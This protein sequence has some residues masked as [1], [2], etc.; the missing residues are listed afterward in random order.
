VILSSVGEIRYYDYEFGG[1]QCS[2]FCVGRSVV[3]L[4]GDKIYHSDGELI[5]VG[6]HYIFSGNSGGYLVNLCHDIKM[7]CT[8]F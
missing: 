4:N 8:N 1:E 3:N 5:G 2:F 7:S 6:E